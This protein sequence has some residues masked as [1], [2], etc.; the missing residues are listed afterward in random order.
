MKALFPILFVSVFILFH[1]YIYF[2]AVKRFDFSSDTKRYMKYFLIINMAGVILYMFARYSISI[3]NF[4]YLLLSLSIGVGFVLFIGAL[5]YDLLHFL[6][7]KTPL[8]NKRRE[9]MKKS[10]DGGFL[11][12]G[13]L[14]TGVGINNGC[15][16]PE[17]NP[18]ELKLDNLDK[19]ITIAQISDLHIGGLVDKHFVKTVVDKINTLGVDIVAITGDLVDAKIE[20]VEEAVDELGNLKAK[21]GAFFVVGNHEYFHGI[22][23]TM[24]YLEKQGIKVLKNESI[25][26]DRELYIA[27][28]YDVFGERFGKYKPDIKPIKNTTPE[29]ATTILLAHQPKY[30]D[31]LDGFKPSLLLSGHTHGG[32]IYP[33]SYLV[34]L[35]QPYLKGLHK[36]DDNSYIYVNRGSGFWG[37]P[38]RIGSSSEVT[39][40][41]LKA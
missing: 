37:P 19:D 28:V 14:Y 8:N 35:A 2:R 15:K 17:I 4:I 12:A 30:I 25:K 41:R 31:Q 33:F 38:M 24:N 20:M 40:L 34:R 13:V 1:L 5:I 11:A 32:Q 39:Y 16:I 10:I 23:N 29:D 27:G 7:L 21:Y 26:L 18:I 3:P 6:H 36:L 22:E 9:F